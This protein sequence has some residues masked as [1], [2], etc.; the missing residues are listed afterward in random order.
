MRYCKL[1]EGYRM[2]R[3]VREE[4]DDEGPTSTFDK[5]DRAM[6]PL[7]TVVGGIRKRVSKK[8][9]SPI[10]AFKAGYD[11]KKERM[12]ESFREGIGLAA[13]SLLRKKK[14]A[15]LG[16]RQAKSAVKS[17]GIKLRTSKGVR[18]GT[19]VTTGNAGTKKFK[20]DVGSAL[21]ANATKIAGGKG[22]VNLR[23]QRNVVGKTSVTSRTKPQPTVAKEQKHSQWASDP[24]K[25]AEVAN[26]SRV[27]QGDSGGASTAEQHAQYKQRLTDEAKKRGKPTV[28]EAPT[29]ADKGNSNAPAAEAPATSGDNNADPNKP[30]R[31]AGYALMGAGA[32]GAYKLFNTASQVAQ[33]QNEYRQNMGHIQMTMSAP[34]LAANLIENYLTWKTRK[35]LYGKS[36]RKNRNWKFDWNKPSHIRHARRLSDAQFKKLTGYKTWLPKRKE[37]STKT[38]PLKYTYFSNDKKNVYAGK[39]VG[40]RQKLLSNHFKYGE[41]LPKNFEN[42]TYEQINDLFKKHMRYGWEARKYSKASLPRKLFVHAAGLRSEARKKLGFESSA[43]KGNIEE[44]AKITAE[45]RDMNECLFMEGRVDSPTQCSCSECAK[46]QRHIL[47]LN[48]TAEGS[49]GQN[50][51]PGAQGGKPIEEAEPEEK[52]DEVEMSKKDF[53]K[54]HKHLFK[55]LKK[56]KT[57]AAKKELKKQKKEYKQEVAESLINRFIRGE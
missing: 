12:G 39:T 36:G 7:G 13:A 33:R 5:I 51:R 47:A 43:A 27:S 35:R 53:K 49:F 17:A 42:F 15:K 32:Y 54:E 40:M 1:R 57:P 6:D 9:K 21:D 22:A 50:L 56:C 10:R 25:R 19:P 45:I 18:A 24:T 44:N 55:V 26:K 31:H 4:D 14:L 28:G 41:K 38:S 29:T 8:L 11:A 2:V 30:W 20:S 52:E 23:S 3:R 48:E 46:V 34:A 16:A 37:V